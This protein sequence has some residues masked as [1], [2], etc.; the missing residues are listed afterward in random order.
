MDPYTYANCT[1]E[2]GAQWAGSSV[3]SFHVEAALPPRS[4]GRE[5]TALFTSHKRGGSKQALIMVISPIAP[6]AAAAAA[7]RSLPSAF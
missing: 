7:D 2:F 5:A 6:N 1:W 4:G 3:C